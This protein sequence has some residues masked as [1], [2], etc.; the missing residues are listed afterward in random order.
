MQGLLDNI[1]QQFIKAVR[2]GRGSRLKETPEMFSGLFWT[3]EQALPLGLIDALGDKK[4]LRD[5]K[6]KDLKMIEYKRDR[7]AFER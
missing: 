6:Y 7:N 1:H 3:G 2:D 4:H 5:A